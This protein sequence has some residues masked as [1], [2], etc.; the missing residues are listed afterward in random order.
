MC[1]VKRFACQMIVATISFFSLQAVY[2]DDKNG[3]ADFVVQVLNRTDSECLFQSFK[4]S[5]GYLLNV[6]PNVTV[7]PPHSTQIFLT[8]QNLVQGPTL[9]L[10]YLCGGQKISIGSHQNLCFLEPGNIQ[11]SVVSSDN[12][13]QAIYTKHDGSRYWSYPGHIYWALENRH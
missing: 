4:M 8:Q 11:G 10:N 12:G 6:T 7:I 3:C 2:A 9:V 5:S 13:I 1:F